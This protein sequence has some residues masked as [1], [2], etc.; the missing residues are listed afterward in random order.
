MPVDTV[1]LILPAASDKIMLVIGRSFFY[2][3]MT[4]AGTDFVKGA[5]VS[6]CTQ[7][8]Q[9]LGPDQTLQPPAVSLICC[10]TEILPEL[11]DDEGFSAF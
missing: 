2:L 11:L 10:A 4:P 5:A 8:G 7:K 6:T 9:A 1:L 3:A